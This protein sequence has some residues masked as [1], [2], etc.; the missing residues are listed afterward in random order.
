MV[1]GLSILL[2]ALE[3]LG[4][5]KDW[6]LEYLGYKWILGPRRTN[7]NEHSQKHDRDS[8]EEPCPAANIC[9][10]LEAFWPLIHAKAEKTQ[11]LLACE[12][13]A[14]AVSRGCAAT[15]EQPAIAEEL[16]PA[17]RHRVLSVE[18]HRA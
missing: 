7:R 8:A 16:P 13:I 18:V 3:N 9:S 2:F 5:L 6:A 4:L 17:S 1:L 10:N 15:P 14:A 11:I 12:S